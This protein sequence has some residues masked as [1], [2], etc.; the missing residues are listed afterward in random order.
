MQQLGR[1]KKEQAN[2]DKSLTEEIEKKRAM[3][4]S[5]DRREDLFRNETNKD[6]QSLG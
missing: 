3:K 4:S 6:S 2:E 1:S 5:L